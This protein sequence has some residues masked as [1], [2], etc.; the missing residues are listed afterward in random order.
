MLPLSTQIRDLHFCA[1]DFESAGAAKGQTD[2]PIQI[3]LARW[4]IGKG[5]G[6]TFMSYLHSAKRVTWA[7]QKVHGITDAQLS[8]APSL[9]SLWPIIKQNL[10]NRVIV[11][12]GKGTEKKF[13]RCF[14]G[15]GFGPWIDT[16]LLSRAIWPHWPDHSLGNICLRLDLEESIQAS[17]PGKTWHDALF[18]AVASLQLLAWIVNSM[19]LADF[20][21]AF[22]VHPDQSTWRRGEPM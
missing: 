14:P 5:M 10:Q 13:L 4:T 2:V 17:C 12:H 20:P 18:D 6:E 7:A 9:L 3:G 11:A 21:L 8:D 1:I 22:F 15:H 19:D 16:L